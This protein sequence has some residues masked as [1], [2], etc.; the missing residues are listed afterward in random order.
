MCACEREQ[1]REQAATQPCHMLPM[2][3][4]K[5]QHTTIYMALI[6]TQIRGCL[7]ELMSSVGGA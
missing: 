7:G 5:K 1:K 6:K 4:L 3:L 2:E